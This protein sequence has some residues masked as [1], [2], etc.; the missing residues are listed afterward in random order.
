ML[1]RWLESSLR[2]FQGIAK[3]EIVIAKISVDNK[4]R[5]FIS[6]DAGRALDILPGDE[7]VLLRH[8][9]SDSLC[10]KIQRSGHLTNVLFLTRAHNSLFT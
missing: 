4:R 2:P 1:E 9:D 6:K 10:L 5:M 8:E 7:L 3:N